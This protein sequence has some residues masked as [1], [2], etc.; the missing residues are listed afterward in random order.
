MSEVWDARRLAACLAFF[1]KAESVAL[2]S[3]LFYMTVE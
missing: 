2:D 1:E 3:C